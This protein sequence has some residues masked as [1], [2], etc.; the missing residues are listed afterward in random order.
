MKAFYCDHF[1]LPL[2]EGHR[3]PMEK[4]ARLRET[5][6]GD[7]DLELRVP[8]AASDRELLRVHTP[9][10]VT[11]VTTGRLTRE[12]I[13]QIGFPWSPELVERSRRSVG[14][15]IA[16]ARAAL[17]EGRGANLAGG[18]H[19]AGPDRGEGFCV[20]NDVAVAARSVQAGGGARR[21][22]VVDLDVHQ[23]NGTARIFARDPSVVTTSVH[24]AS[25]YPFRKETSDLDV[26]LPD[27]ATDEA[28][29]EAIDRVL[30]AAEAHRPDLVFYIAGADPYRG[31][32]LG[33]LAV[34]VEGLAER[35]RRVFGHFGRL[36]VPVAVVMAG[37]YAP[38]VH[39]IVEIHAHTIR[40]AARGGPR[41][42]APA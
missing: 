11:E 2:P 27:G 5:L 8:E 4:Y 13:R 41:P 35:D 23:G 10:Y 14:G 33:R 28:W 9:R 38:D 20:F 32:A 25:N 12:A 42:L 15:T 17:E 18:T 30:E 37:G 24:G 36:G 21:I 7:D 31:D 40:E 1:V 26:A 34:S 6:A 29:L 19:H 39:R 22:A 16:A 3:F